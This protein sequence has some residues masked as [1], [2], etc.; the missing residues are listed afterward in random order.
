MPAFFLALIAAA[1][2]TLASREALRVARLS[3]ALGGASGLLAALWLAEAKNETAARKAA[4]A[5]LKRILELLFTP[6]D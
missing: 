5:A 4:D 2:A 6:E 1:A 3:A